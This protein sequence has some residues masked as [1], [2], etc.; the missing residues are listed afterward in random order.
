[1]HKRKI[2]LLWW[3]NQI[4]LQIYIFIIE[5][6]LL[7]IIE[8]SWQDQ[9]FLS[10]LRLKLRIFQPKFPFYKRFRS[11]ALLYICV[12]LTHSQSQSNLIFVLCTSFT[13]TVLVISSS[14]IRL[15]LY[16][17]VSFF[18]PICPSFHLL[19]CSLTVCSFLCLIVFPYLS[20][21]LL[22]TAG[23]CIIVNTMKSLCLSIYK[24]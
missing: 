11:E 19:I 2:Y 12:S 6:R 4:Q 16:S 9:S 24:L 13:A 21:S 20:I 14:Q 3:I 22:S 1:M 8:K 5:R 15:F 10:L 17:W 7:T 23:P 18:Y